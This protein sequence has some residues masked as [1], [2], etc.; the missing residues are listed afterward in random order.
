MC[1][2]GVTKFMVRLGLIHQWSVRMVITVF[3]TS[4]STIQPDVQPIR[5]IQIQQAWQLQPGE[6]VGG[7]K[8][9]AGLGEVSIHL[10]GNS[11]HAPFNGEIQLTD[12]NCV[13]FSSADVPAYLFRL[14]G[15][16]RPIIG[17]LAEGNAIGSGEYLHFTA[18]RRQPDGTWT[19]VEPAKNILERM[20]Q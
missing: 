13:L 2:V 9:V 20:L 12:A 1:G 15:L 14:C 19:I 3:T 17:E 8:I 11:V 5:T 10:D 7:R 6:M 4:C 16:N 18:M